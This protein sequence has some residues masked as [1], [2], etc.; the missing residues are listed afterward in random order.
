MLLVI[1]LLLAA[2]VIG[3]VVALQYEPK[4][5]ETFFDAPL[6]TAPAK[7][8]TKKS[9][10]GNLGLLLPLIILFVVWIVFIYNASM[11]L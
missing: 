6:S 5:K 7:K 10:S 4:P 8:K 1:L 11:R 9:G 2:S 3:L